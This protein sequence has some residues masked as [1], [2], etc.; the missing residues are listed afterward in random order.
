LC[1]PR[2]LAQFDVLASLLVVNAIIP[3]LRGEMTVIE[4]NAAC[5]LLTSLSESW[6]VVNIL[7][8]DP[9]VV[10]ALFAKHRWHYEEIARIQFVRPGRVAPW[11]PKMTTATATYRL[12]TVL[13][14]SSDKRKLMLMGEQ[15]EV[16]HEAIYGAIRAIEHIS[17][18]YALPTEFL[19]V[20]SRFR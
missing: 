20:T 3:S 4:Q 10:D 5:R 11:V 13:A 6:T 18:S 15:Q 9:R 7:R 2:D 16:V 12:N 19:P 14:P 8:R 1:C 17:K